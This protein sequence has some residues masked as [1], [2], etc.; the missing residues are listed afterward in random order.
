MSC[1]FG[2]IEKIIIFVSVSIMSLYCQL[3]TLLLLLRCMIG[4]V[5]SFIPG[6]SPLDLF[7]LRSISF[8]FPTIKT[9]VQRKMFKSNH[10]GMALIRYP[11]PF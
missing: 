10:L 4:L 2:Y 3:L 8:Y 7:S 1:V 11:T 5:P 6:D 9:S